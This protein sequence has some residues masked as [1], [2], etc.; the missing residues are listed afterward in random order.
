MGEKVFTVQQLK[1]VGSS[2][3]SVAADYA[4]NFVCL[5]LGAPMFWATMISKA[6]S[7]LLNYTLNRTQ[8]FSTEGKT[9][10]KTS[11]IR[12]YILWGVQTLIGSTLASFAASLA[13]NAADWQ[14]VL[15]RLPIDGAIFC[16][17]YIVQKIWVFKPQEEKKPKD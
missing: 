1:Y 16:V 2:L 3:A 17:N 11:I 12:Y 7:S 5:K 14:H 10:S 9:I 13:P 6:G 4:I 8:V 15:M